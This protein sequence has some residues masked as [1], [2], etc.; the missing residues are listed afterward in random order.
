[1]KGV[2]TSGAGSGAGIGSDDRIGRYRLLQVLGEGGMGVVHL[3]EDPEGRRVAIKVLRPQVAADQTAVRR[4]AREVDTMRRVQSPY[5]AEIVD[6]DVTAARPY[7]VTRF[8]PGRTLEEVVLES[9]R[10][11]GGALQRLAAGLAQALAAIHGAGV[12][13]RDL[14][15]GNVM[16]QGGRGEGEPVLIDFGIAQGLDA[17]RLTATGMV[18]GTPGYLAPEIIEGEEAGP[19]ADIHAWAGTL[20]FAATGRPP[21]GSGTFESIFFKIMQ[22]T[23]DLSGVPAPMLPLIKAAMARHPAER[24]TAVNLV[25]LARRID[26]N[27]TITDQTRVDR[28]LAELG[29][30]APPPRSPTS[31]ET[32]A[33]KAS[34][35]PT[36]PAT[37]E[38]MVDTATARL[39]EVAA[40]LGAEAAGAKGAAAGHGTVAGQGAAGVKGRNEQLQPRDFVGMLP[41]AAPPAPPPRTEPKRG[42]RPYVPPPPS[43]R[44]AYP[45]SAPPG[46]QPYAQQG[47]HP[48]GPGQ[49]PG[50]YGQPPGAGG[51]PPPYGQQPPAGARPGE[52]EAKE[53]R[54]KP[55]GWYRLCSLATLAMV[56][57]LAAMAPVMTLVIALGAAAVLRASDRAAQSM[58]SKRTRRGPGSGDVLGAVVKTPFALPGAL[59]KTALWGGVHLFAGA[60]LVIVLMVGNPTMTVAKALSYGA[61]AVLALH[62]LGPGSVGPRRQMARVWSTLLPRAEPAVLITLCLGVFAAILFSMSVKATP[63]LQPLRFTDSGKTLDDLRNGVEGSIPSLP[64]G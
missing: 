48:G 61:M 10:L 31:G 59:L 26:L 20:A 6:A 2:E 64:F 22:G 16:L 32:A 41:P 28:S 18:I 44:S 51:Y 15:P 38:T 39:P 3:A 62:F 9:G 12:I 27:A 33:P 7:V 23:P 40:A 34:A 30:P 54:R 37:D 50:Q 36:G 1:M 45:A 55:Y 4:L 8:V 17:S 53:Q 14:K 42:P 43:Q 49:P 46:Y 24:P 56:L 52:Q 47:Q 21:F 25:Q 13:H 29:M 60:A 57:G 58:E 63:D 19:P 35:H 11:S 5:V